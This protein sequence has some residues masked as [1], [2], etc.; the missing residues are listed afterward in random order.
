M[1]RL[2]ALL[3]T[4]LLLCGCQKVDSAPTETVPTTAETTVPEETET[5]VAYV[6]LEDL[7]EWEFLFSSGVG[8]WGTWVY[9]GEDGSFSGRF[10]DHDNE[11]GEG[12]PNGITYWCN[13]TGTFTQPEWLSP[14]ACAL[15]VETLEFEAE[16]GTEELRDQQKYV[17][18]EPRGL[19]LG[20]QFLLWLPGAPTEGMSEEFLYWINMSGNPPVDGVLTAYALDNTAQDIGFPGTNIYEEERQALEEVEDR[21]STLEEQLQTDGTLTQ[22]DMNLLSAEI[23]E[24]W[25]KE[26]NRL[27]RFLKKTLDKETM[28]VLTDEELQWIRDKEAAVAAAGE[29]T[30]GGSLQPLL[31]GKSAAELTR[32][33]VYYLAERYLS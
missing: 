20:E 25:D 31:E 26:L 10:E 28:A 12:Y 4:G 32:E 27:W 21:V 16:P 18:D 22:T 9:L 1:K 11:T 29:E 5:E 14:W 23:Y 3:L 7:K 15:T 17:A 8:S 24:I 30:E 33:R 6:S 2:I 19:G 13:F